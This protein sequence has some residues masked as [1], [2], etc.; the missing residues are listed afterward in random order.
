MT[1]FDDDL[2][3]CR[4]LSSGWDAFDGACSTHAGYARAILVHTPEHEITAT[5]WPRGAA[6]DLHGHG[7]STSWLEVISGQLEEERYLRGPDGEW[8][9]ERRVLSSGESSE[10]PAGALH[11]LVA[12]R[13]S[14]VLMTFSPPPDHHVAPLPRSELEALRRARWKVVGPKTHPRAEG[15]RTT[16]WE[17]DE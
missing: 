3:P 4:F 10:L 5:L 7:S 6:G 14:E 9:Y 12:R 13:G 8:V 2:G 11:R 16:R 17:H 1:D 15:P